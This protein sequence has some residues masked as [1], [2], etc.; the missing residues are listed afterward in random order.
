MADTAAF[1]AKKKKGKKK[2]SFNANNIDA[3][4]VTKADHV[5]VFCL[6]CVLVI[7]SIFALRQLD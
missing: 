7:A 1:F 5:Y 3:N 2:F 4:T 6:S